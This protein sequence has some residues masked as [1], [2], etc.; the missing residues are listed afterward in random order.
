[1]SMHRLVRQQAMLG[2][3]LLVFSAAAAAQGED[4]GMRVAKEPVSGQLRPV[5]AEEAK[6]LGTAAGGNAL[7]A[8][9]GGKSMRSLKA[10]AARGVTLGAEH[11]SNMRVV[12]DAQGHLLEE[13]VEGDAAPLAA[14]VVQAVQQ[15]GAEIE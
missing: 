7:R 11:L 1:M 2:A 6:A 12:K 13:C 3:C 9:P 15:Q 10:P 8:A 4:E 5:T 14:P